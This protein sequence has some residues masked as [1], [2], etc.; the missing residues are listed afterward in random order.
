VN[1]AWRKRIGFGAAKGLAVRLFDFILLFRNVIPRFVF[2]IFLQSVV[3]FFKTT[4]FLP[5]HPWRAAAKNLLHLGAAGRSPRE[6]FF[7]LVD[8]CRFVALAF[9]DAHRNGVESVLPRIRI[10][11]NAHR[12]FEDVAREGGKAIVVLPHVLAGIFSA[13]LITTKYKTLILSRGPR[14]PKRA[15][16][17]RKFMA[18]LGLKLLV[19]DRTSP[20]LAAR[21]FLTAIKAGHLIVGTTDLNYKRDDSVETTVFGETVHFPSWPARFSRQTR[22]PILPGYVRIRDG[23]AE[24]DLAEPIRERDVAS[25]TRAWAAAFE[26]MILSSP[27]DWAFLCDRRWGQLLRRAARRGRPDPLRRP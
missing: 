1:R 15:E 21:Q 20:V 18:P 17:Q 4:W 7:Q 9:L 6:I 19:L 11:E 13:A 12:I 16:I 2:R 24:V 22:A 25:A 27:Q 5:F 14:V 10:T 8:G 26:K 3:L 23:F